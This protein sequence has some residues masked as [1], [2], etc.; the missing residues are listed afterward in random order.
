[1]LRVTTRFT[2]VP[3]SPYYSTMYF[4]GD[5]QTAADNAAD[6][7]D[8]FWAA[9]D[10]VMTDTIDWERLAEVEEVDVSSGHVIGVFQTIPGAGSGASGN[11]RLSGVMQAL[12]RW[13]TGVYLGGREIRGRTFIP[14]MVQDSNDAG[15]LT[16]TVR[17][18]LS[19]YAAGLI[20]DA[21]STLVCYSPTHS[22]QATVLTGTCWS[23]YAVLR[24]RRG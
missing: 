16:G 24:S 4:D 6:A 17:D 20:A 1:M 23:E 8:T 3:G 11:E 14:G 21:N 18:A 22:A 9:A 13:R 19:G 12:I 15:V 2:G 7:V 5:D 10:G